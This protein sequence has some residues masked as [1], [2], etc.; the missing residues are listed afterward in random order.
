MWGEL[1][2]QIYPADGAT[3]TATRIPLRAEAWPGAA[4]CT[5]SVA[6]G[7]LSEER[8]FKK[9]IFL[10]KRSSD[11]RTIAELPRYN[12]AY[13]W[14]AEYYNGKGSK[15]GASPI[16]HFRVPGNEFSDSNKC[17]VRVIKNLYSDTGLYLLLDN[18]GG[19]YT[20]Q[21]KPIWF[22][23]QILK[24]DPKGQAT[25]LRLS[26]STTLTFILKEIAYETNY[27]GE[28]L[29][30]FSS[31]TA[32]IERKGFHHEFVKRPNGNYIIL[33]WKTEERAIPIGGSVKEGHEQNSE[34]PVTFGTIEEYDQSGRQVWSW[35]SSAYFEDTDLID[36]VNDRQVPRGRTH[37]NAFY[38]DE[39][40]STIYI[41]FKDVSRIVKLKYPEKNILETYYGF[42]PGKEQL[43][44]EQHSINLLADNRMCVYSNNISFSKALPNVLY[45]TGNKDS[46]VS[47]IVLLEQDRNT[48][49]GLKKVWEFKCDIDSEAPHFSARGGNVR[50]L[51]DG[52]L[53]V[54]MGAS[55]RIFIVSTDG[56]I[57]FNAIV[58]EW[59]EGEKKWEGVSQYRVTPVTAG[60]LNQL[61]YG[62]VVNK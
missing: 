44:L 34:F 58:E 41:G 14:K 19:M 3:M 31:P 26:G 29:W 50:E 60:Q 45:N 12:E 8:D 25:N 11:N 20:M 36:Q 38:F 32:E 4:S 21:G 48:E 37:M 5:F 49:R 18:P 42:V 59:N 54:C 22:S 9:H 15:I 2:A 62:S 23:P 16:H 39:S 35:S 27:A 7:E 10:V 17:R 30:R 52:N 24:C 43:F 55:P 61:I 56:K 53:L 1:A 57:L 13:S 6:V 28:V 47:S 33:G 46:A 51:P 40:D